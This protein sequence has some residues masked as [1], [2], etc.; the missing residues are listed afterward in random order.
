MKMPRILLPFAIL[1]WGQQSPHDLLFGFLTTNDQQYY[2]RNHT[3]GPLSVFVIT[4]TSDCGSDQAS[5]R[6]LTKAAVAG[7]DLD[8]LAL[9]YLDCNCLVHQFHI[10]VQEQLYLLDEFLD[11]CMA[12]ESFKEHAFT[13]YYSSLAK[14]ASYWRERVHEVICAWENIHQHRAPDGVNP[15]KYPLKVISGRWGSVSNA[16]LFMLER[17]RTF[18]APV[19]LGVLSSAVRARPKQDDEADEPEH[20]AGVGRGRARGRGMGKRG[21]SDGKAKAKKPSKTDTLVDDAEGREAYQVKMSKW[22]S[23]CYQAIRCSLF[24]LCLRVMQTVR[25]PLT[26][27]FHWCEKNSENRLLFQLVTGKAD[28]FHAE[29]EELLKQS[30]KW[31]PQAVEEAQAVDI[32]NELLEQVQSLCHRLLVSSAGGF[33]LRIVKMTR[34]HWVNKSLRCC[35]IHVSR[36]CSFPVLKIKSIGLLGSGQLTR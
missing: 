33:Y 25:S 34:R 1:S 32:P 21:R 19:L 22:A 17:S 4:D 24:W 11:S 31:F 28:A 23:G 35:I 15:R 2:L 29:F 14:T 9:F 26:H 13:K 16:E 8:G 3:L 30:G 18:L 20:T 6:K 12:E 7:V 36:S 10:M 27:F 5:R